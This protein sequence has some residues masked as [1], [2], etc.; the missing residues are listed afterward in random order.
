MSMNHPHHIP[1]NDI[2]SYLRATMTAMLELVSD[3]KARQRMAVNRDA[4]FDHL[5]A[6]KG[7]RAEVG[8]AIRANKTPRHDRCCR[9]LLEHIVC[10]GLSSQAARG[11]IGL[12]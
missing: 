1:M 11:R 9:E 12:N 2:P 8:N 3:A 7:C 5:N 10:F 4:V 6:C